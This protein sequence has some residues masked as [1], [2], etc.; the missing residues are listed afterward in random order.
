MECII[1]VCDIYEND[2]KTLSNPFTLYSVFFIYNGPP[3][4][5]TNFSHIPSSKLEQEYW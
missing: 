1:N 2:N 5:C 4:T 3:G